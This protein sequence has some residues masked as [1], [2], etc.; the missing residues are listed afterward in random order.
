MSIGF[1]WDPRKAAINERKHGVT[2]EEAIT[3]FD[4]PLARIFLDVW[5]S[6][7]ESRKIII[8]HS[9][10]GSLLLVAFAEQPD[11]TIRVISARPATPGEQRDYEHRS[12]S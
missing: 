7:T 11:A 2:F 4:D 3:V 5:H 12:R 6:E 9:S 1:Q 10:A 8:G